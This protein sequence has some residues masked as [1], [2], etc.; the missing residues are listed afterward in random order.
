[1]VVF[2][3]HAITV[4]S[5][6]M[7]LLLTAASLQTMPKWKAKVAWKQ[8][9]LSVLSPKIHG[10]FSYACRTHQED[11]KTKAL[12]LSYFMAIPF[13]MKRKPV[14]KEVKPNLIKFTSIVYKNCIKHWISTLFS[15]LLKLQYSRKLLKNLNLFPCHRKLTFPTELWINFYL[16]E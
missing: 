16:H 13:R 8:G 1:M 15:W 11:T 12:L 6:S 5:S 9:L 7:G 14:S 10:W 3:K 4:I 2:F